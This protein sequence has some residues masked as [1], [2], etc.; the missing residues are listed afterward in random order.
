MYKHIMIPVDLAEKAR[1]IGAID[2]AADLARHYQAG[3]TLVSVTGGIQGKI[4]HST[5]EYARQLEV[6][7][8]EIAESESVPVASRVYDVP[9][10]SVEV[11]GTLLRAI[12]DLGADLVVMASHQPGWVEYLFNS[13]GGRL[14]SHAPVSVM[15]VRDQA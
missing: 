1:V 15:V 13:H 8:D 2:I 12:A 9:D 10:P 3:M 14:A 11:D 4:S 7:A 6:F 5:A